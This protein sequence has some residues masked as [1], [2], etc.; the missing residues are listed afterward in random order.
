MQKPITFEMLSIHK[1]SAWQ[2][3]AALFLPSIFNC[4]VLH[5]CR[6]KDGFAGAGHAKAYIVPRE[7]RCFVALLLCQPVNQYWCHLTCSRKRNLSEDARNT[8]RDISAVLKIR[9][10]QILILQGVVGSS[11]WQVGTGCTAKS[12][13][14]WPCWGCARVK[15]PTVG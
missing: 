5:T 1:S 7:Q 12:V 11:P 10:F 15:Q 9:T 8:L 4:I 14:T 6:Y 2:C 3:Q 13:A